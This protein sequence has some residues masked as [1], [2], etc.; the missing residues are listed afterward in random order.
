M[1]GIDQLAKAVAERL[2][3]RGFVHEDPRAYRAGVDDAVA[4]IVLAAREAAT[5][6]AAPARRTKVA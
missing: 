6:A 1:E 5:D 3:R 4:A 2:Q